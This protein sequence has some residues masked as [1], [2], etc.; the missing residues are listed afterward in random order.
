MGCFLLVD[1]LNDYNKLCCR[2]FFF[3]EKKIGMLKDLSVS[4]LSA[5]ELV[6]GKTCSRVSEGAILLNHVY[7]VLFLFQQLSSKNG[8]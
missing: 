2:E 8:R 5:I 3:S 6:E 4:D 1:A 7:G